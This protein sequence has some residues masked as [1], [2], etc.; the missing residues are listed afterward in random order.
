VLIC[1]G[2]IGILVIAGMGRRITGFSWGLCLYN[3]IL[4]TRRTPGIYGVG[5][6]L[7]IICKKNITTFSLWNSSVVTCNVQ[8][9]D[10]VMERFRSACTQP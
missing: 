1:W 10:S 8:I 9:P 2:G 3:D 5:T 6:I 7:D 4:G